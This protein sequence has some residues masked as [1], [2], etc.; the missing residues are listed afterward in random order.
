MPRPTFPALFPLVVL[1][2]LALAPVARAG[3]RPFITLAS[4]TSTENSGLFAH[5]LPRFTARTGI[6]VRVI[7]VGTGQA[8]RLARN[9]DADVLLVHHRPAE[10]AFVAEGFGIERRD[11]MYNDFVLVGPAGD[12]AGIAGAPDAVTALR[13]IA[14]ARSP[15]ASRGDDSGTHKLERELWAAAGIDAAAASGTWYREMGNGMGA[16]LNAAVAMNAYALSD[17]ATW[18][19][20]GNRGTHRLLFAGDRALLNPY[21]AIVVNPARH[22]QVKVALARAFVDWLT[23]PEGRAAIAGFRVGGEQPFF[24]WPKDR[25]DARGRTG[26]VPGHGHRRQESTAAIAAAPG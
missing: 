4:T 5:L 16:T 8:L 13:R 22:P 26:S 15:F 9:G 12:P 7:A 17:R 14:A 1:L 3:E 10:D 19:A 21:G 23:G 24:P 11:V 6:A 20:F 18:L 25:T 2:A